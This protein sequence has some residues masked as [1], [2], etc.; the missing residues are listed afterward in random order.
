MVVMVLRT[1]SFFMKAYLRSE[2]L[3]EFIVSHSHTLSVTHI[4]R[5]KFQVPGTGSYCTV[6][7]STVLYYIYIR[8]YSTV[9][10]S[11]IPG[12]TSIFYSLPISGIPVPGMLQ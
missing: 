4:T 9:L 11:T 7:Y 5:Y 2:T 1:V 8:V 10:Y 12:S 3:I 6:Q